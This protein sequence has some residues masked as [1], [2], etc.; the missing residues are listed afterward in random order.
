MT[1]GSMQAALGETRS[2]ADAALP[3]GAAFA[4]GARG[5]DAGCSAPAGKA[6]SQAGRTLSLRPAM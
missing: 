1:L 6:L 5:A 3:D 2:R 4:S